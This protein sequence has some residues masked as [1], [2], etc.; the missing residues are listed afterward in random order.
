MSIVVAA[1]FIRI[2]PNVR[3]CK[4]LNF[5]MLINYCENLKIYVIMMKI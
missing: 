3:W 2:V 1:I 4:L 5:H